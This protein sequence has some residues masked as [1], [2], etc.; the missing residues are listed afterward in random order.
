[1]ISFHDGLVLFEFKE[2]SKIKRAFNSQTFGVIFSKY[3]MRVFSEKMKKEY[4]ELN[5]QRNLKNAFF[6]RVFLDQFLKWYF[7]QTL[8]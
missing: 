8:N 5:I 6:R 7:Q 2:F 1:M 3:F 4:Y